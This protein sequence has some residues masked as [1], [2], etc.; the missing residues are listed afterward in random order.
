VFEAL[1][2]ARP[3][4]TFSNHLQP[5]SATRWQLMTGYN[6]LA[7]Q[8]TAGHNDHN[9]V[10]QF[11][12]NWLRY[13]CPF[14]SR[15]LSVRV[16]MLLLSVSVVTRL[17]LLLLQWAVVPP[18]RVSCHVVIIINGQWYYLAWPG[19]WARPSTKLPWESLSFIYRTGWD[20]SCLCGLSYRCDFSKSRVEHFLS[21]KVSQD[22]QLKEIT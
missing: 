3:S 22:S 19:S 1:A 8:P 6:H 9:G 20:F 16:A 18:G 14:I 12:N 17:P 2:N 15:C 5:P 21:A 11:R 7:G 4:L 10:Q 13:K